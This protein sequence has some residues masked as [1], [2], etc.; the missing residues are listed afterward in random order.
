MKEK[1]ISILKQHIG[2]DEL[3]AHR[4]HLENFS[5][6][7]MHGPADFPVHGD[8]ALTRTF[9]WLALSI[10]L[11]AII[12][13]INLAT[14]KTMAR[15]RE[16]AVRKTVGAS[17]QQLIWLYMLESVV[18]AF[19]AMLL[20]IGLFEFL[21]VPFNEIF[22]RVAVINIWD[23][24]F[25]ASIVLFTIVVGFC[26][27]YYP[28]IY[29]SKQ[30]PIRILHN[31]SQMRSSK[32]FLRK[33]LLFI[34]FGT[35]IIFISASIIV[36]KELD[37]LR[38]KDSGFKKND[39]LILN[40]GNKQGSQR[41]QRFKNFLQA[42]GINSASMDYAPGFCRTEKSFSSLPDRQGANIT[43]YEY[44]IDEN[45]IS[46][47]GVNI[48]KDYSENANQ[49][50]PNDIIISESIARQIG[51]SNT[52][53][54]L[55]SLY[56]VVGVAKNFYGGNLTSKNQ[57]NVVLRINPEKATTLAINIDDNPSFTLSQIQWLWK[58]AF[59]HINFRYAFLNDMIEQKL[60]KDNDYGNVLLLLSIVSV[61][62]ACLGVYGLVAF[63]TE[64][65]LKEIGIRRIFGAKV[66]SIIGAFNKE[67]VGLIL[68]ANIAA[69]PISFWFMREFLSSFAFQ[70]KIGW[71]TFALIGIAT[72][73]MPVI[74]TSSQ[75]KMV[76]ML[77]PVDVL[78]SE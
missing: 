41:C 48:T 69:W 10:L 61:C 65:K 78:R 73:V 55:G 42:H 7:Y 59:P 21:K 1:I 40:F 38:T 5:D 70:V 52:L 76:S 30:M 17:R 20:S 4:I 62:I 43:S 46:V 31:Q 75:I 15:I 71:H 56:N 77:N 3:D 28:A 51:N 63:T 26:A 67:F 16:V 64:T 39:I 34:Q 53:Y 68:L 24:L 72:F 74:I 27:G 2:L 36:F 13:Y 60:Y 6:S 22:R 66:V 45:F 44:N 49:Y 33:I 11:M 25:I 14:A 35:A 12:N 9:V 19:F 8:P 47:F 57:P 50:G 18:L 58:S 32:S 37:Y 29:L 54:H 23:P